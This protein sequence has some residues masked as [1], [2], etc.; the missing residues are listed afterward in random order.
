MS[1]GVT[2]VV[3]G[4]DNP[5]TIDPDMSFYKTLYKRHTNFSSVIDKL[6]LQTKPVNNGSSTD[7]SRDQ[8]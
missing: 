2:L 8:G 4:R 1:S 6:T 3:S 7:A 5:L